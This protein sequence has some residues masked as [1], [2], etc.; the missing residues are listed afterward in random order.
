MS[1]APAVAALM[2]CFWLDE[3]LSAGQWGGIASVV[4][5]SAGMTLA[6]E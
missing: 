2:G 1:L 4:A 6:A 3:Q 5:A